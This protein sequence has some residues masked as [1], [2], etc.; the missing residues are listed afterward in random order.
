MQ[1]EPWIYESPVEI[2]GF[3]QLPG[4]VIDDAATRATY[5][6]ESVSVEAAAAWLP[7]LDRMIEKHYWRSQDAFG[8]KQ[9]IIR[10]L[11][12]PKAINHPVNELTNSEFCGI[13]K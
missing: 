13:L 2:P 8:I 6:L 12:I 5:A 4:N 7:E 10:Q 1:T 11:S 9:R 3:G